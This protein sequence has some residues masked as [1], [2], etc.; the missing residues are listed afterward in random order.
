MQNRE[1]LNNMIFA[2]TY[3]AAYNYQLILKNIFPTS[4]RNFGDQEIVYSDKKRFTFNEFYDRISRF[5][6]GLKEIGVRPGDKVAV[7]DWDTNHYMESYFSIPMMGS[8]LHTVNIR[9]PPELIYLTMQHAE[10]KFVIIR[11]EFL[12][13]IEKYASMFDFIK[14]WIVYSDENEDVKTTLEPS[15]NYEE[16][17]KNNE[18]MNYPDL[19]ENTQATIF[20]TSGTTG[21]PK[22]V[23]FTHRDLILHATA[24]ASSVHREPLYVSDKDVF[25]SLVPLFHVHSWGLPYVTIM[26]GNKYVLPGRYDM[27]KILE[28]IDKEKVTL[29]LM[30]PSILYMILNHPKAKE[31][32][33]ALSRW[34]VVI[35]GA[36]LPRGLAKLAES[37]GITTIAGYGMS[38]TCPVLTLALYK[39][40]ISK[41]KEEEKFEYR[42]S[43]G[44]PILFVHLK[45]I[46]EYGKEVPWDGKTIG[47]IVVRA[48]WLT[49]E[50]YKD[51][52]KTEQLWK[53]GWLHTGDLAFVDPD[54]YVHIVDREKDAIKSGGEFIPSILIENI[55][56]EMPGIGEV[57]L[58][59][60]YNEKWGERPVL[61]VKKISNVTKEDIY[62]HLQKYLDIGRIQ[63]FWI[64]DDVIFI[65]E[66]PK[67]STGKTDKKALREMYENM[68]K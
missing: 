55:V 3:M 61:F 42:I 29:S 24:L 8:V 43:T 22:G 47:E 33:D 38:E 28:L 26:T 52:E 36:A 59:G 14:G 44:I 57:A 11:D 67:T 32:K 48:P 9:Y 7:L 45:V 10:D 65:E 37:Y 12:P 66:F 19:D 17:V 15:Y 40:K 27:G 64:P 68:K 34:K 56:S 49:K 62:R 50:Y 58:V 13:L 31:Y 46:N 20:Y 35:G 30:V 4:L 1:K 2:I 51:P 16:L 23:T 6:N 5:S 60:V 53:D 25:M 41:M 54:G 63:K 39:N 21:L 18:P